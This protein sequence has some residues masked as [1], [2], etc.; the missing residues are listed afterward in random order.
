MVVSMREV[1]EHVGVSVGTVS[2]V[3]NRPQQ[4]N[5]EL[6]QRVLAGIESLGYVRNDVA[7]QLR[8][9]LSRTIGMVVQD[10]SN[11]FFADMARGAEDQAALSDRMLIV[12]SSHGEPEREARYIDLF[13]QQRVQG[14]FLAP[15]G[16][17]SDQ[18]HELR[19]RGIAPVLVQRG[20]DPR[21]FCSVSGDDEHG[22]YLAARHLLDLGRRHIAFV[23]G[24]FSI[25]GIEDRLAG[26]RMAV[27]EVDG[28]RLEEF[29]TEGLTVG[30]GR[31]AAR[32]ILAREISD[33]PDAV[34]TANDL[35]ALGVLQVFAMKQAV[36]IPDDI[37]LIG[38]DDISFTTAAVVPLSTIRQPGAM[39][40]AAGIDLIQEEIDSPTGHEHRNVG[41]RP[42]LVA[43]ASTVG[44]AA[45]PMDEF[46]DLPDA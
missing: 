9:G 7:R 35:V 37:A 36:R 38:Y 40:G 32:A 16:G 46:D 31:G 1:A 25:K 21:D 22:G 34:F 26:A 18:V 41:F 10:S 24:P 5:A 33:R 8:V 12:G 19:R 42:Q 2:N 17:I 30:T 45:A 11:P 43:R 14:V 28:A 27:D 20:V 23:G 6:V 4:V 39:L 44:F 13:Q 29:P 15:L 3:L